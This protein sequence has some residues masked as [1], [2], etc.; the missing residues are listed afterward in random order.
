MTTKSSAVGQRNRSR[1][2]SED[3]SDSKLTGTITEISDYDPTRWPGSVWISLQVCFSRR[4]GNCLPSEQDS[5]CV[6]SVNPKPLCLPFSVRY[7]SDDTGN[8]IL[9]REQVNWDE[10]GSE[11]HERVSPW[12]IA[13]FSARVSQPTQDRTRK[14][15]KAPPQL[16][17]TPVAPREYYSLALH[18][19]AGPV[20]SLAFKMLVTSS[21][22][23][24]LFLCHGSH[25]FELRKSVQKT[26]FLA[27]IWSPGS[28]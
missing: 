5:G 4:L 24:P 7:G 23:N 11:R 20:F 26:G 22:T 1:F 21:G 17:T 19:A 15:Y 25:E 6:V 12:E 2:E 16:Q 10:A 14:R 13:P 28:V 8:I 27:H 3:S 9:R 18:G